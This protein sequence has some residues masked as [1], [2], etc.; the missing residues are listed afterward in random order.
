MSGQ[1]SDRAG[2]RA[3]GAASAAAALG[4]ALGIVL[5]V[6][7]CG[8]G[9]GVVGSGGTGRAPGNVVGTVNGFGSVVVDGLAVDVRSARVVSETVPGQESVADVKL[10]QRVSV[11][12]NDAGVA[13][14]VHVD[15]ALAG[16]VDSVGAD[17]LSM[18]GQRVDIAFAGGNGPVTQFGGGLTQASDLRAGDAV[19]VHGVL[20]VQSGASSIRATRIDKL[21]LPPAYLRASGIVQTLAPDGSSLTFG[22]LTADLAGASVLPAGARLASGQAVTLLAAADTLTSGAGTVHVRAAE[23]RIRALADSAAD[24]AVSGVL[25]HVDTQAHTFMLGALLVDYAA[26]TLSPAGATLADGQY[27]RVQGVPTGADA[28]R[29]DTVM[30][31]VGASGDDGELRG[32]IS[33]YDAATGRFSVRDVA[34][35]ASGAMLQGC[36]AAGLSNGLFV[37]IHGAL[38]SSGIAAASIECESEPSEATVERE[39]IATAVD[40]AASSFTLRTEGGATLVVRWSDSTYFGG[41]TPQTLTGREVQAEGVLDNGVLIASKISRDD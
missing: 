35:D 7:S 3:S 5:S 32:N 8:G 12:L 22:G 2:R 31:R 15:A 36:P 38:T 1:A 9:G 33:G 11:D 27:A 26:A 23:V 17:R 6:A 28:L 21:A 10:G 30:L 29:A 39:G 4:L 19:E 20:V 16:P 13:S 14:T 18:L 24:Q 37:E 41:V 25:S 34:V 40:S